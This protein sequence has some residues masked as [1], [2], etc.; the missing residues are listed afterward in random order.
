MARGLPRKC[1][2]AL[3]SQIENNSLAG[4]AYLPLAGARDG[5]GGRTGA[6]NAWRD[7]VAFDALLES[8]VLRGEIPEQ[9]AGAADPG[10]RIA[11]YEVGGEAGIVGGRAGRGGADR[12]HRGPGDSAGAQARAL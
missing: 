9:S 8:G 2:F 11:W 7:A 4:R 5:A 12:T 3:R 6:Q 1:T 10:E